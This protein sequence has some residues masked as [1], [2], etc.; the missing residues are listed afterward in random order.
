[1]LLPLSLSTLI[2][3]FRAVRFATGGQ[4][5]DNQDNISQFQFF[6]KTAHQKLQDFDPAFP[7]HR[8]GASA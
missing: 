7:R 1:L 3:T 5:S 4:F 8:Q 2:P 6:E